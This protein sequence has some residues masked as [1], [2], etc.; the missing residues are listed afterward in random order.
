MLEGEGRQGLVV[1]LVE[2]GSVH[3]HLDSPLLHLGP[4]SVTDTP[5]PRRHSPGL[6]APL[7]GQVPVLGHPSS[8]GPVKRR[9]LVNVKDPE[10]GA[11]PISVVVF[12][13]PLLAPPALSGVEGFFVGDQGES[14]LKE[15]LRK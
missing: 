13:V 3:T 4:P 12:G 6:G 8:V 7:G 10:R 15:R 14:S 1:T 9:D 5:A 11:G 2:R